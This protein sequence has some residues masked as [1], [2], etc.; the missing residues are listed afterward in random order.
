MTSKE[1]I[2]PKISCLYFH[3]LFF[4]GVEWITFSWTTAIGI[5]F[6]PTQLYR[7]SYHLPPTFHYFLHPRLLCVFS[8][9]TFS[10][11]SYMDRDMEKSRLFDSLLS[12]KLTNKKRDVWLLPINL[13]DCP[14]WLK[15]CN[16]I[17]TK[18]SRN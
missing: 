15:S 4:C 16:F 6:P 7:K 17:N 12:I 9:Q 2:F 3:H 8:R 5:Q 18:N 10:Y 1:K 13:F 14:N 11:V